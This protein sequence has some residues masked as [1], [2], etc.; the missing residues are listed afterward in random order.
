VRIRVRFTALEPMDPLKAW[1]T[2][3]ALAD[4]AR[5]KLA[6]APGNGLASP[7]PASVG[8]PPGTDDVSANGMGGMAPLLPA[9]LLATDP[10]D[11]LT[12]RIWP[13]A[14][15]NGHQVELRPVAGGGEACE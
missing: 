10:G 6:G 15:P 8:Y 2:S 9:A 1:D 4:G 7:S 11:G 5:W 12:Q 3:K 14:T 13:H